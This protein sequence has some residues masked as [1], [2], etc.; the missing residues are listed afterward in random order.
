MA[1]RTAKRYV[2]SPQ[3]PVYP[4]SEAN[5]IN[6]DPYK[7]IMDEWLEE[8]PYSALRILEKLCEM[9]FDGGYS[10]DKAM[11]LNEKVTV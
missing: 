9:W 2:E 5:P 10:I 6:M 7:Q 1:P 11:D 4:L 8:V 3:K